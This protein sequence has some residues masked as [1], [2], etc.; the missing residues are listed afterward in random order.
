MI[1][2]PVALVIVDGLI[3]LSEGAPFMNDFLAGGAAAVFIVR[4]MDVLRA[5]TGQW[6]E[7][8]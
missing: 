4:G 8:G 5:S 6:P 1:L 3:H 7:N 2:G